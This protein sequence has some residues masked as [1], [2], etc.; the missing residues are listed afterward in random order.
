MEKRTVKMSQKD[1]IKEFLQ[2]NPSLSSA[3]AKEQ[4]GVG[5]LRA[6]IDELRKSG[7]KVFTEQLPSGKYVYRMNQPEPA[8]PT[9]PPIPDLK[10]QFAQAIK[11]VLEDKGM[12]L[13]SST[14]QTPIRQRLEGKNAAIASTLDGDSDLSTEI[15]KIDGQLRDM[16][17]RLSQQVQIIDGLTSVI[18][19]STENIKRADEIDRLQNVKRNTILIDAAKT[20][21][22]ELEGIGAAAQI[23]QDTGRKGGQHRQEILKNPTL[24]VKTA[25]IVIEGTAKLDMLAPKEVKRMSGIDKEDKQKKKGTGLFEGGGGSDTNILRGLGALALGAGALSLMMNDEVRD[26]IT[27]NLGGIIR[28]ATKNLVDLV[29]VPLSKKAIDAV[30]DAAMENPALAAYGVAPIT[31]TGGSVLSGVGKGIGALS[32]GLGSLASGE[33]SALGKLSSGTASVASGMSTFSKLTKI[34]GKGLGPLGAI[35]DFGT[36]LQQGQSLAQAGFGSGASLVGATIGATAGTAV[37]PIVGT[38]IG[39]VVGGWVGGKVGDGV[40]DS[41]RENSGTEGSTSSTTGSGSSSSFLGMGGLLGG[42]VRSNTDLAG[43]DDING[44]VTPDKMKPEDAKR[45]TFNYL[46]KKGFSDQQAAGIVGNFIIETAG[47]KD[48]HNEKEGSV[49]IAQWNKGRRRDFNKKMGKD[50]LDATL[51]EQLDFV[52]YELNSS[53]KHVFE[54]LKQSDSVEEAAA[55]FDADFEVSAGK[56]R[57]HRIAA[58]EATLKKMQSLSRISAPQPKSTGE[59]T[60]PQTPTFLPRSSTPLKDVAPLADMVNTPSIMMPQIT[61]VNAPS[62]TVAGGSS[63]G[64]HV[65]SVRDNTNPFTRNAD[66][67]TGF[68]FAR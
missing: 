49:G 27:E 40:F 43:G 46:K 19:K 64:T 67:H 22:K 1:R 44:D 52:M 3:Q 23:T 45:Y 21:R 59:M 55:I 7:V 32:K 68:N 41:Y 38:A 47:F 20:L 15:A 14:Q 48:F 11:Q 66:K 10:E 26:K 4:L 34:L 50:P 12:L 28:G 54:S 30:G 61:N 58:G 62:T 31:K 2:N 39:A 63:G 65:V 57:K 13:G 42:T 36:R 6:R 60:V 5:N 17:N 51:R 25:K 33:G 53:K 16:S 29:V 24:N 56:H 9:V 8:E 18:K 37:M 35:I